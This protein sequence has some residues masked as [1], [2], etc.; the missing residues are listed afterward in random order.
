MNINDINTSSE[1]MKETGSLET[2]NLNLI[3]AS[4]G[5]GVRGGGTF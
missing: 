4:L 1:N 3:C 5:A 2:R